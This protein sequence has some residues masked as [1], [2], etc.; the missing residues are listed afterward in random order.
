MG[1]SRLHYRWSRSCLLG[2]FTALATVS[3]AGLGLSN[4]V[5]ASPLGVWMD[6]TGRG[7]VEISACGSGGELCGK[8]VWLKDEGHAQ[9]CGLDILGNVKP[10]QGGRW[11]NGWIFDPDFGQ[12]FDVELT[13]LDNGNLQVLGYAGIKA[14]SQTMIWTRSPQPLK[15]CDTGEI[16]S[17]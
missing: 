2:V 11:D 8:L 4:P 5:A 13:P 17:R 16:V 14:L 12:R 10:V 15:R 3:A 1:G 7:A 9:A 6:H